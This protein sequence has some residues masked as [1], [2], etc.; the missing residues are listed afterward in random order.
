[1]ASQWYYQT[2]GEP[3]KGPF[4]DKELKAQ[5]ESGLLT[6]NHHVWKEGLE[7]W[8]PAT[9]IKGLFTGPS[10]LSRQSQAAETVASPTANDDP[11]AAMVEMARQSPSIPGPTPVASSVPLDAP[12]DEE[13]KSS[14]SFPVFTVALI[15]LSLIVSAGLGSVC[16]TVIASFRL[17][18]KAVKGIVF[19][20]GFVSGWSTGKLIRFGGLKTDFY[21]Y[22]FG[23]LAG[24][25]ATFFFWAAQCH[26]ALVTAVP[27][28]KIS[29]LR[30]LSPDVMLSYLFL[31]LKEAGGLGFLG[32]LFDAVVIIGLAVGIAV[33]VC[34]DYQIP[35]G[36]K[37]DD[38]EIMR[39][40]R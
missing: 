6:P 14:F 2:H 13:E 22:L 29:F 10:P 31:R 1:M 26:V 23:G 3:R 9:K 36:E 28:A 32:L 39:H 17:R 20:I 11:F 38:D 12:E 16:G 30:T 7:N 34:T 8:I 35:P 18:V 24:V 21:G 4:S 25:T 33:V 37:A 5:A 15:V 27:N 40:F 19:I